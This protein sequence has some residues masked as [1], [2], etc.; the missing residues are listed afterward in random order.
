ML[1]PHDVDNGESLLLLRRWQ[2]IQL[3]LGERE[4]LLEKLCVEEGKERG[5]GENKEL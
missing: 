2:R 5:N 1:A 4:Q 3:L